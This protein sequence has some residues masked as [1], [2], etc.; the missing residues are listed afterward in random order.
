[1]PTATLKTTTDVV[2]DPIFA[3]LENHQKLDQATGDLIQSGAQQCDIDRADAAAEKAAWKL[4]RIKPATA[5]GAAAF[6]AYITTGPIT[7]L[8]TLG[9][10]NWHEVAFRNLAESLA[11][12]AQPVTFARRES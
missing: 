11:K 4:A 2:I 3:A 6:A 10:T 12:I 9:E 7:G 5:A 8:F 1:M